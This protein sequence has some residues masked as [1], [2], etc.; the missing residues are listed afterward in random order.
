VYAHAYL[1]AATPGP[2]TF[3]LNHA[4]GLKGWVNGKEVYKS[5]AAFENYSMYHVSRAYRLSSP[6]IEALSKSCQFNADLQKGWNRL[7]FKVTRRAGDSCY[8]ALRI[9]VPPNTEYE[10]KN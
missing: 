4:D 10:K 1:Y 3:I 8:F 7:L 6:Y 2:A 9:T 5:P